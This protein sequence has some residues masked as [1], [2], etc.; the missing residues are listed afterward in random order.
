MKKNAFGFCILLFLSIQCFSQGW[1]GLGN[2]GN[3][4]S[5]VKNTSG[6]LYYQLRTN[7]APPMPSATSYN[8]TNQNFRT[9]S[10]NWKTTAPT[11]FTDYWVSKFVVTETNIGGGTGVPQF[12]TPTLNSATQPTTAVSSATV[13]GTIRDLTLEGGEADKKVL[14][15]LRGEYVNDNF[16]LS[17]S[18]KS[19]NRKIKPLE[20]EFLREDDWIFSEFVWREID[21]REKMNQAFIY[22]G[23]DNTGD[24]RFL[25]ILLNSI[26][27]DSVWAFDPVGEGDRF[28]KRIYYDDIAQ[29]I[30]GP[31][32][33]KVIT[34]DP[35]RPGVVVNDV[36]YYYDRTQGLDLDSV[37]TFRLKE[38]WIVDKESSR[39]Y[40]RIIGI[41]PVATITDVDKVT[42]KKVQSK[43]DLFWVYYPDLRNSL[44]SKKVYN[45]KN[46]AGRM[47][48]EEL[49]ESRFFS[50][51]IVK[52]SNNNP[53]SKYL[54]E[55]IKN[56]LFRLLE[57]ENIKERIFNYEQDLWSY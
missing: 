24:Q 2:G 52:S 48:W 40:C 51:Y 5:T 16:M 35:N 9:L 47:T 15:S 37:Y 46:Y 4:N 10:A 11:G 21:A 34:E 36:V 42:G 33:K 49:F 17:D 26:K 29:R 41:C 12:E 8:F 55:I 44:I 43:Q 6:E 56:P 31:K 3:N 50:S 27:N 1:G 19:F 13:T 18:L 32:E 57:G 53:K 22:P 25:S 39:L 14:K 20:Y 45:P 7:T 38:Q 30:N 23:V 28:T 54:Q